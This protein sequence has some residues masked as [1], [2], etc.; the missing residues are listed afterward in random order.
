M[1]VNRLPSIPD[2]VTWTQELLRSNVTFYWQNGSAIA[3]HD[4]IMFGVPFFVLPVGNWSLIRD[5]LSP[6]LI[7]GYTVIDD[8]SLWGW[9]YNFTSEHFGYVVN[10]SKTYL[11]SDGAFYQCMNT[12]RNTT[13]NQEFFH[14]EISRTAAEIGPLS[15]LAIAAIP[16][17][18]AVAVLLIKKYRQ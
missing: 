15:L 7:S 5:K 3:V 2:S 8:P 10:I 18:I 17:E 12:M 16:I 1:V 9:Q 14:Y 13:T 11:K 4:F 6:D